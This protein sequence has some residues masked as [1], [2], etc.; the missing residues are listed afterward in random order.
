[1]SDMVF[2]DATWASVAPL[3]ARWQMALLPFPDRSW[4]VHAGY[5]VRWTGPRLSLYGIAWADLPQAIADVAA[6]CEAVRQ[7]DP[8]GDPC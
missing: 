1:M 6:R 8:H 5:P 2:Q 3:L 4:D 7:G